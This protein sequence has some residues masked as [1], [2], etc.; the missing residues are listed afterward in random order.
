MRKNNIQIHSF[1]YFLKLKKKII[2]NFLYFQYHLNF[3]FLNNF[4]S[5][6]KIIDKLVL[7]F[8]LSYSVLKNC[9]F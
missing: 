7:I 2:I 8:F 6:G 9:S 1:N 3:F 5:I 4:S